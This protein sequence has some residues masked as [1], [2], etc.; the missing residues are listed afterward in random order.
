MKIHVSALLL[1]LTSSVAAAQSA[2]YSPTSNPPIRTEV[3]DPRQQDVSVPDDMRIRLAIERA[4]SEHRKVME[5]VKKLNDLSEDIAKRYRE[6]GKFSGEE[7]KKVGT[8][9]KLAK[10]ILS[11]A[12]GSEVSD[13]EGD[14]LR[15]SIAEAVDQLSV[16]ASNIR[17][18]MTEETRFV[19][20]A[21]VIANSNEVINLAQF[22]R[23]QNKQTN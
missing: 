23:R 16:A 17:K 1:L 5:D 14:A 2:P 7:I 22:I 20:S 19:V 3:K 13:K 12:G 21:I 6:E 15:L 18:S 10:R 9:E 8:I 11:H 4:E